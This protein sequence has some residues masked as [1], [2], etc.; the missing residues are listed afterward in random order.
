M[1]QLTPPRLL[2]LFIFATIV[3]A[4]LGRERV[5]TAPPGERLS[6]KRE[7]EAPADPSTTPR[8]VGSSSCATAACHG[9][10][11]GNPIVGAEF[12]IW[13]Q[14]DPHSRAYSVLLNDLSQQMAARLELKQPP[15]ES[16]ICLNCHSPAQVI[17]AEAEPGRERHSTEGVS[18]ERCHGPAEQWLTPH[19]RKDWRP[20]S[21]TEK[22]KLGFRDLTDVLTRANLCADCHVG[23]PGLDVNHDLIAAGHPRL[24]VELSAFHANWPKHF[25]NNHTRPT[26]ERGIGADTKGRSEIRLASSEAKLWAIGQVVIAQRSMELLAHRAAQA[27]TNSSASWPELAE[28]NCFACHH[29][30]QAGSW[31]QARSPLANASRVKNSLAGNAWPYALI[32]SLA[33]ETN[34]GELVGEKSLWQ[35]LRA[36]IAKPVPPPAP[37][38]KHATAIATELG[39]WAKQLN[40]PEAFDQHFSAAAID[41]LRLSL[42]SDVGAK[43]ISQDWDS[44][45]QLTLA[46]TSLHHASVASRAATDPAGLQTD[47]EVQAVIDSMNESLNFPLGFQSPRNFADKPIERLQADLKR[48][49]K[50]WTSPK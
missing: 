2:S 23:G 11:S 4:A 5:E 14:R 25:P 19:V 49:R 39:A 26:R 33:I 18:C 38:Q 6:V 43:L 9:G 37:I 20:R 42:T 10:L 22:Q 13:S 32:E 48:L 24:F 15:H 36:L 30:L 7:A 41:K 46:L 17:N 3:F 21:L 50:L 44:A 12:P 29:D 45:T 34:H 27:E 1:S 31:R 8:L 40:Q 47:R 35:P 28:W 16:A